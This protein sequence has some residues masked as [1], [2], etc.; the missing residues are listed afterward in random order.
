MIPSSQF[1][2]TSNCAS[3]VSVRSTKSSALTSLTAHSLIPVPD[4]DRSCHV[5]ATTL[6]YD[7]HVDVTLRRIHNY[8]AICVQLT[9]TSI[10]TVVI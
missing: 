8:V 6:N 10:L 7:I 5:T 4:P 2:T 3:K 1:L 9:K